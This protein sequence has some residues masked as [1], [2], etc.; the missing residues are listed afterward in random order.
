[1]QYPRATLT[2][3]S[4]E[5]NALKEPYS[6]EHLNPIKPYRNPCI[7]NNFKE[8]LTGT[9]IDGIMVNPKPINL[10]TLNPETLNPKPQT[11]RELGSWQDLIHDHRQVGLHL[12]ESRG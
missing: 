3:P 4:F 1:M 2:R 10:K 11:P 5:K 8:S 7:K 6:K 12:H 9:P